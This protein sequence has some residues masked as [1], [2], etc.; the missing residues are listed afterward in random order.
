MQ[1]LVLFIWAGTLGAYSVL[2]N[3]VAWQTWGIM[4]KIT[5]NHLGTGR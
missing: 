3:W 1:I 5:N 4:K 2:A